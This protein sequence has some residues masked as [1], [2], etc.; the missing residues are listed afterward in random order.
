MATVIWDSQSVIY[1]DFLEKG[2]KGIGLFYEE[3]LYRLDSEL[4]KKRPHLSKR[5]V[6]FHYYIT[7]RG[8]IDRIGI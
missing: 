6:L 8:Q 1:I 3:L 4:Q 7:H 2:T 5:K